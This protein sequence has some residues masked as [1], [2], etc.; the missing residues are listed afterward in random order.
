M[1]GHPDVRLGQPGLGGPGDQAW[2][3]AESVVEPLGRFV[4]EGLMR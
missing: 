1:V 3:L 4:D 2:W